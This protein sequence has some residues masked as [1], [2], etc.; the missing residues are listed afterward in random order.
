VFDDRP[1]DLIRGG[2]GGPA[3]RG[4][5]GR[6]VAT[7][8]DGEA[9]LG[10]LAATATATCTSGTRS[11]AGAGAKPSA[12][13]SPLLTTGT[14]LRTF[15][16]FVED[17]GAAP[18]YCGANF[19]TNDTGTLTIGMHI[20]N[21]SG[22]SIDDTYAVL[23]DTDGSASTGGFRGGEYL[24][25]FDGSMSELGRW[26]GSTYQTLTLQTP[27][28]VTW[29]DGLGPAIR[30]GRSDLG[31]PAAFDFALVSFS[32]EDG[33]AAPDDGAWSYQLAP[34]E[35][36]A[37]SLTVGRAKAG[38]PLV[39]RL[40]VI[41][42]DFDVELTEGT[43]AC[44]AKV[45]GTTIRGSGVFAGERARCTWRVPRNARGKTFAGSV[46]VTFDGVQA[47]RTFAV[48]VR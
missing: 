11:P 5:R 37:K 24:L 41:R 12:P 39:A 18:D 31:N 40:L 23:F 15:D 21:R 17:A 4:A 6:G 33:D 36:A 16:D 9:R 35:L 29:V 26:D 13:R 25:V 28:A 43:I 7:R 48:K 22:F 10:Q 42:T 27:L 32:G 45:G 1:Q 20:H 8:G 47:K 2:R 30:I 14:A 46:A 34:F 44:T 38:N 19:V 3:R